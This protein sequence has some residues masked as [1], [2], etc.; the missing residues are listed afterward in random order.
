VTVL[1]G[2]VGF[3]K[4]RRG[5]SIPRHISGP[6]ICLPYPSTIWTVIK[7]FLECIW[8]HERQFWALRDFIVWQLWG[9]HIC[10]C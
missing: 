6:D 4:A 8:K 3:I 7:V 9:V 1:G 10:L 2:Q 5:N